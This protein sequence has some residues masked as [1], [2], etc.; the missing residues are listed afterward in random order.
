MTVGRTAGALSAQILGQVLTGWT[1]VAHVS[2]WPDVSIWVVV[3]LLAAALVPFRHDGSFRDRAAGNFGAA[4][5]VA[6][7]LWWEVLLGGLDSIIG[8]GGFSLGL[9]AMLLLSASV[10]FSVA[11]ALFWVLR[12]GS[13]ESSE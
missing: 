13:T 8:G 1:L 10:L 5:V 11:G 7:F 3:F 4:L 9:E 6:G 12:G 2:G